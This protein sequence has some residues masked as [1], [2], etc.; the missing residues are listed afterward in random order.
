MTPQELAWL[1]PIQEEAQDPREVGP[2]KK[3]FRTH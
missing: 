2:R 1:A 3:S